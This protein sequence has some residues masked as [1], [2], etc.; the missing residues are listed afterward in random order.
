MVYE[1]K[2]FWLSTGNWKVVG[3]LGKKGSPMGW[4]SGKVSVWA[5]FRS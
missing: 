1:G 4:S 2:L 3:A 5:V